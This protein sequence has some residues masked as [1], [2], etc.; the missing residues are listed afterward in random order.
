LAGLTAS[1]AIADH[2]SVQTTRSTC[3]RIGAIARWQDSGAN[4]GVGSDGDESAQTGRWE[5]TPEAITLD[6]VAG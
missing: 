1:R 4:G 3:R 2:W 6:V 5:E